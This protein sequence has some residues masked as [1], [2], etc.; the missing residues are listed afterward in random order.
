MRKIWVYLEDK[1]NNVANEEELPCGG[2]TTD[3][4]KHW[5]F[6]KKPQ[7]GDELGLRYT[8]RSG[9]LR[10]SKVEISEIEWPE[11]KSVHLSNG[12]IYQFGTGWFKNPE[13]KSKGIFTI[14]L[15]VPT[16][17]FV[18]Y[19]SSDSSK[20]GKHA[21]WMS[22]PYGDKLADNYYD[23]IYTQTRVMYEYYQCY[24]V[25]LV[26]FCSV[27]FFAVG[28]YE[29]W[30]GDDPYFEVLIYS[31][32]ITTLAAFLYWNFAGLPNPLRNEGVSMPCKSTRLPR[33]LLS[34][35]I[36]FLFYIQISLIFGFD[37]NILPH[38]IWIRI[39][40]FFY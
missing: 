21:V 31:L 5:F 39:E 23:W 38:S 12:W 4:F 13:L 25:G 8:L 27:V 28:M 40:R 3:F 36:I 1:I 26:T 20:F 35:L 18:K 30:F 16:A 33:I 24:S 6:M 2:C 17:K 37:I 14:D 22:Q 11:P 10:Y 9:G 19:L 15:V 7:V 32:E 34:G 29:Y